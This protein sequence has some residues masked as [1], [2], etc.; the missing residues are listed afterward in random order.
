MSGSLAQVS[1]ILMYVY[2]AAP[3][4]TGCVVDG[5]GATVAIYFYQIMLVYLRVC[6]AK[7]KFAYVIINHK[8][9]NIIT[10]N[11]SGYMVCL[12]VSSRYLCN[13]QP[14]LVVFRL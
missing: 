11:I 2:V 10:A 4:H 1:C 7:V 8:T 13:R 5:L 6:Y 14:A 9:Q 12:Y 3:A